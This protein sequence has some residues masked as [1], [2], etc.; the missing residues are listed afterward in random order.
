MWETTF[1]MK[2]AKLNLY[3]YYS[4]LVTIVDAKHILVIRTN[5]ME[6]GNIKLSNQNSQP[7]GNYNSNK[8]IIVVVEEAFKNTD[9]DRRKMVIEKMLLNIINKFELNSNITN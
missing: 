3:K 1:V 2:N 6:G 5:S 7:G 4:N 8:S 9:I